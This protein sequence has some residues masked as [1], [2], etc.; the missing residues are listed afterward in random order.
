[1]QEKSAAPSTVASLADPSIPKVIKNGK[2]APSEDQQLRDA[3]D[4]IGVVD[5]EALSELVP[6]RNAMQCK[7]RWTLFL[8]TGLNNSDLSP[9][10]VK[11]MKEILPKYVKNRK[12]PWAK[13]ALSFP[14]RYVSCCHC[15]N[16]FE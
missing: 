3:V 4:L 8:A 12:K 2:W 7:D 11:L 14:N 1:V 15:S 10:E 5:W 9:G 16:D 6:S 13:L